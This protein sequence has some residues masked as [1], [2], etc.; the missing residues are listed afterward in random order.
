MVDDRD[1]RTADLFDL[2]E[3]AEQA[4]G[5]QD[6]EKVLTDEQLQEGG[7]V[8]VK[9]FMRTKQS[10]NALRVKAKREKAQEERGVSQVNVQAPEE[11][12]EPIRAIAKET[13]DGKSVA[14]AV[15]A[16]T[17]EALAADDLCRRV[18]AAEEK[19]GLRWALIRWL[20]PR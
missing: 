18:H 8:P 14:E 19:G 5:P 16:V 2:A 9:A 7:L 4:G 17:G 1:D 10:R 13:R 6:P 20:M 3:E 15:Q 11:A 12:Q